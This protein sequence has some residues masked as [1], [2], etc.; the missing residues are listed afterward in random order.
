MSLSPAVTVDILQQSPLWGAEPR[1]QAT[2]EDA[3]AAAARETEAGAGEVS[4]VLTDDA[5]IRA[6]NR[7]W[8]QMDKPTNVLSFPASVAGRAGGPRLFGDIIIAYET[9]KRESADESKPLLHHLAHL[10]V[11]GFL[12]LM[13]YDHESDADAETM[14]RLERVILARLEIPDPYR[15]SETS[16]H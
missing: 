3:I 13:G 12:H 16:G 5:A 1:A 4:V 9:L 7:D 2:V 6:L 10:T 11:H 8:R 15:A 14:E